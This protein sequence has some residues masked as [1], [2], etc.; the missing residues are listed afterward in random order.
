MRS[1]YV[2]YCGDGEVHPHAGEE[3]LDV[4]HRDVPAADGVDDG[5]ADR[6]VAPAASTSRTNCSPQPTSQSAFCASVSVLPRSST[7]S[8]A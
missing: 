7:I 4:V 3:R 1:S 2:S 8:S 5:P 6:V